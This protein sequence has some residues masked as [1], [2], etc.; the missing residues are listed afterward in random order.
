MSTPGSPSV[1]AFAL[2]PLDLLTD[3]SR[4]VFPE[5]KSFY[6]QDAD[7]IECIVCQQTIKRAAGGFPYRMHESGDMICQLRKQTANQVAAAAIVA[8]R[9]KLRKPL[10]PLESSFQ[11]DP[12]S[13]TA[14]GPAV[15]LASMDRDGRR[16]KLQPANG[17]GTRPSFAKPQE[18]S[19]QRATSA[20]LLLC[21]CS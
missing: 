3:R 4:P 19:D 7:T 13:S 11:S 20:T 15:S 2:S 12:Y 6:Q 8:V 16:A 17:S 21:S 1:R 14:S 18:A 10:S 5:N 9:E